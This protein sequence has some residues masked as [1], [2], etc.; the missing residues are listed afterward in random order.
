MRRCPECPKPTAS[1]E[2]A[3]PTQTMTELKVSGHLMTLDTGLFCI[4]QTPSRAAD[5]AAGLP[6]VR[7]SLPARAARA[8]PK[9]SASAPSA[10]TAG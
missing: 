2:R 1:A 5:P 8:G 4:V 9:R 7:I 10:T 6:G 3:R